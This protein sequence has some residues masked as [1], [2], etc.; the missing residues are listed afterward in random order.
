M[1]TH[2]LILASLLLAT[3][4]HAGDDEN[5]GPHTVQRDQPA[6]MNVADWDR[7]QLYLLSKDNPEEWARGPRALA[8]LH[9]PT[10]SKVGGGRVCVTI[11]KGTK[12][13]VQKR[14]G[15]YECVR[16]WGQPPRH[17]EKTCIWTNRVTKGVLPMPA[18]DFYWY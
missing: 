5:L 12:V 8:E 13:M 15:T 7:I 16:Y 18:V 6:C 14:L 9:D 17:Y 4:A 2:A 11:P 10:N 1:K 3:A